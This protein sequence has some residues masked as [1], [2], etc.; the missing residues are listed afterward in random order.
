MATLPQLFEEDIQ[1]FES[2]LQDLL[3]KTEA[4]SVLIIDKGG[5]LI[6]K[7]GRDDQVDTTTLGALAAA[8]YA[9]TQG[10]ASL[11]SETNFRSVYQQGETY[12]LLVQNVDEFCLLAVIFNATTSV[13]AV[14]YYA[15]STGQR[16]ADQLKIAHKRDPKHGLDLAAMDVVDTAPLFRKK[17]G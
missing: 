17:R 12:S 10:M 1:V 11:V 7:Y 13:G 5:F 4:R 6:T 14:K 8:S 16:I 3:V 9:A 2:A 15:T